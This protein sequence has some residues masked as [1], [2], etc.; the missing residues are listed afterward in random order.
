MQRQIVDLSKH[1]G[2]VI[3]TLYTLGHIRR[4][5]QKIKATEILQTAWLLALLSMA[6]RE[7]ESLTF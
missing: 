7:A 4:A 3:P 2:A 1:C 5:A 6:Q